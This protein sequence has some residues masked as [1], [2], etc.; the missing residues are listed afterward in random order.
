[1]TAAIFVL[2]L[3]AAILFGLSAVGVGSRVG[4]LDAG[5]CLMAVALILPSA[6]ALF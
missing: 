6:N 2:L 5:L 1:M 3:V 4:L